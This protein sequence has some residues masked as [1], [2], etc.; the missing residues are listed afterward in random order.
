MKCKHT[1]KGGGKC[2][3]NAMSGS[4]YCYLHNPE[5]P[6]EQKREAQARGGQA[7]PLM[8]KNPLPPI[9]LTRGQEV[10]LLLAD[11]INRVRAGEMDIRVANCLGVLSGQ[12]L[13]AIELTETERRLDE[14]EKKIAEGE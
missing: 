1:K 8:V 6:K 5:I 13:K 11:T 12:M 9:E 4:K 14:L 7:N 10:L 2:K 3:A